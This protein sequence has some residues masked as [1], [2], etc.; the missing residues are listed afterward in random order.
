[1]SMS[2]SNSTNPDGVGPGYDWRCEENFLKWKGIFAPAL[3]KVL[4]QVHPTLV[5]KEDALEYMESLILRLLA[6]LTAKPAPLSVQDVED[7]ITKNI[8]NPD[9]QMGFIGSPVCGGKGTK[10][11][12]S[13]FPD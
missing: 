3:Q 1:M 4:T 7:R 13:G 10:E 11:I 12:L 2:V 9:R 6:M 8:S 5:A